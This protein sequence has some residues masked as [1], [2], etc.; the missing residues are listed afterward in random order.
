MSEGLEM[1]KI[2][3]SVIIA[4]FIVCGG[5][6]PT[7][8]LILDPAQIAAKVSDFVE[9]ISDSVSKITQQINQVKMMATQGY[10]LN[11][12]KNMAKR[13]YKIDQTFLTERMIKLVKGTKK[14][15]KEVLQ[16]DA[17]LYKE[18]SETQAQEKY[19]NVESDIS[20]IDEELFDVQGKLNEKVTECPRLKSEYDGM[21]EGSAKERK[22]NEYSKCEADK[23]L[24]ESSVEELQ[25]VKIKLGQE[26]AKLTA[27]LEEKR[28][29][30]ATYRD[31]VR[32]VEELKK[33]KDGDDN[34]MINA[35]DNIDD[36]DEW[37]KFGPQDIAAKI[38]PPEGDYQ[39]FM[40]RYFY[41]PDELTSKDK[42]YEFQSNMDRILR[43]RRYLFINTAV[44]LMQVATTI[45]REIPVRTVAINKMAND[46]STEKSE[47]A[48]MSA[49]S[50]TRIEN[51]KTLL[52][53]AQLM[54]AKLQYLAARDLLQ[55]DLKKEYADRDNFQEFDLGRYLLDSEYI[56]ELLNAAN[57]GIDLNKVENYGGHHE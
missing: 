54:S 51:I 26:K 49:Y 36:D 15:Q 8:A 7:E 53:Y 48:A 20:F 35:S 9:K 32:R 18:V 11:S 40:R 57:T 19:D 47:I 16:K 14:K 2:L 17:D 34:K 38:T 23:Q 22:W 4:F 37:D 33:Q 21:Q 43:E 30:D 50:A 44:H 27:E 56:E 25:N 39:E 45:R 29:G 24:L 1:R 42:Q 28:S 55:A 41:D 3:V 12:L 52:L 10:D 46:T 5:A 6:K 31:K 13:Y